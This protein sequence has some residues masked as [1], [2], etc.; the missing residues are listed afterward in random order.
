MLSAH[1]LHDFSIV[2]EEGGVA[3]Y[4]ERLDTAV[5]TIGEQVASCRSRCVTSCSEGVRVEIPALHSRRA[6]HHR[7]VT[8]MVVAARD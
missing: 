4:D 5:Q 6:S 1:Q 3:R 8:Q 7:I 2:T